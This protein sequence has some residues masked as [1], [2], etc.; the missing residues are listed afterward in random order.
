MHLTRTWT[1][2]LATLLVGTGLMMFTDDT[3]AADDSIPIWHRWETSF[4]ADADPDTRLTIV[5]TSPDGTNRRVD[6]FWDGGRTW[7][8]R[9]MPDRQGTWKYRTTSQ[10]ARNGLDGR[11]G[12]FVCGKPTGETRFQ[13]HGPVRVSADGRYFEHADDTPFL[14]IVD[15]AW[16]GVLKSTADGWDRYLDNRVD[17]GFTGIQFVATQWRAAYTNAEGQT[18]YTGYDRIKIRPEFFRRIDQRIDRLNAK[19]LLAVPVMLWT[20]GS[21]EHN[22][23]QL[24]ESEAIRL[25]RYLVARY[26]AN[27]VVWFLPGDGNYFDQRVDRW[28]RIGRAVFDTDDHAPVFMHPQGMQWPYDAFL[29]EPWLDALGY[30]SGHGDDDRTLAWL[31]SGPPAEKY[32]RKPIRPVVNLEPPYEDHVAYQSRQRHTDDWVLVFRPGR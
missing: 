31:H 16:N 12:Q 20:L 8:M 19:G 29:K 15:T 7:R 28:K 24:P 21:R 10:P 1:M 30:Q 26:G 11:R 6:G 14:W 32:G 3:T 5:V 13:Q 2:T 9:F 22:P 18:A 23:G 17:N 4:D 25:A 27:H